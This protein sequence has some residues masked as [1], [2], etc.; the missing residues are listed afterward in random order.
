MKSY[1]P[2]NGTEGMIFCEEWCEKCIHDRP[3]TEHYCLILSR[4]YMFD[5][6]DPEYPKEWIYKDG[7]PCCTK[8]AEHWP[9]RKRKPKENVDQLR[10]L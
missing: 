10:L 3:E 5:I 7:I 9:K 1:Q 8:F 4:S 2:S 6:D